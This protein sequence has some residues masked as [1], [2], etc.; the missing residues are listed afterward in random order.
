M[1]IIKIVNF[2][3]ILIFYCTSVFFSLAVSID[4]S[5][6]TNTSVIPIVRLVAILRLFKSIRMHETEV[7]NV[8]TDRK[9]FFLVIMLSILII[10]TIFRS[11]LA[12][13]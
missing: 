8:G 9:I 6:S 2:N 5:H 10:M 1:T 4:Y 7:C 11:N 12:F 3:G 13:E